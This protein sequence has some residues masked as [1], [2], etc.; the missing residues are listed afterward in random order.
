MNRVQKYR[1]GPEAV[2]LR[3]SAITC[4]V[5]TAELYDNIFD[6]KQDIQYSKA[7]VTALRDAFVVTQGLQENEY[8]LLE[9][10][11]GV[12]RKPVIRRFKL[13]TG[14][15]ADM[16]EQSSRADAETLEASLRR[17]S[18]FFECA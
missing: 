13:N 15:P 11:I 1:E 6:A 7:C 18:A 9:P 5:T 4:L 3:C 16:L 17:A 2:C 14:H 12:S 10:Y 8:Y